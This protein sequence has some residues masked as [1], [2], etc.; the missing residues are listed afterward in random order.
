MD[1]FTVRIRESKYS[2]RCAL[3]TSDIGSA[4]GLR[5]IRRLKKVL[6]KQSRAA[7]RITERELEVAPYLTKEAIKL[8]IWLEKAKENTASALRYLEECEAEYG[9]ESFAAR[10][11]EQEYFQVL[12]DERGLERDLFYETSMP[13][14]LNGRVVRV[15]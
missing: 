15:Y 10:S 2:D 9:V 6:N 3:H 12:D 7:L 5:A 1:R 13:Y 8:S 4:Q 11:A 14:F